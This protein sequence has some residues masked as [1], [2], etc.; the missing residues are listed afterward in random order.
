MTIYIVLATDYNNHIDRKL[1]KA[2]RDYTQ[3]VELKELLGMASP[4]GVF[5]IEELSYKE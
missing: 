2:F 4:N 3:A 1:I 5:T